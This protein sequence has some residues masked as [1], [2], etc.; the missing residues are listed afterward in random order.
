MIL[1][2]H[3]LPMKRVF[4][5]APW[6]ADFGHG[7]LIATLF[8]MVLGLA[9]SA[10]IYGLAVLFSILPDLDGI[11]EF[12]IFKNIGASH[13]R[14]KDHREGLHYPILW[15]M[16]G[17]MLSL[18]APLYGTL[19]LICTMVHFLN[20]SWG[21]GWGI[22]WLWPLS[23][24]SYKFFSS[25]HED[26]HVG[27]SSFIS[28]LNTTEKATAIQTKGNPNWLEDVYLRVT[29]ISVIEYSTFILGLLLTV[30]HLALA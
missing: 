1:L 17:T 29:P 7:L 3:R 27:A 28:S 12:L 10:M 15:L 30:L 16:A 11:P 5:I 26:A 24:N 21:T 6:L 2:Q 8:H 4:L 9:P 25:A 22:K 18:I 20:D 19:F 13:D 14:P 23:H